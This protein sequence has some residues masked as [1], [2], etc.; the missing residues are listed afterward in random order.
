[1]SSFITFG[2]MTQV[3][4]YDIASFPVTHVD[5]NA[6]PASDSLEP[7]RKASAED[8]RHRLGRLAG[9][10]GVILALLGLAGGLIQP[11]PVIG[12]LFPLGMAMIWLSYK[13]AG[14]S[15][16]TGQD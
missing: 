8:T 15:D 6:R 1:M 2:M 16:G 5:L 13:L 10:A 3:H 7:A 12:A 9:I 14:P 11:G 4:A